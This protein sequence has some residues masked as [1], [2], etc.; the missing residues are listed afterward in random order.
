MGVRQVV[1]SEPE[2]A[3]T[4]RVLRWLKTNGW[5]TMHISDSRMV[6]NVAG[7]FCLAADPECAGFPDIFAVHPATGRMVAI[8]CK[9]GGQKPR[10]N[11]VTWLDT[12]AGAGVAT[13]VLT[14]ANEEAVKAELAGRVPVAA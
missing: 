12:L 6:V 8:E 5:L 14:Q 4:N 7:R 9:R 11:Q 10:A 13:Y 1:R 2:Q 3:L